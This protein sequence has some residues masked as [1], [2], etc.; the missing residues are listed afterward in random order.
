[1]SSVTERPSRSGGL[2][3]FSGGKSARK[4]GLIVSDSVG[5]HVGFIFMGGGIIFL[6]FGEGPGYG[7]GLDQGYPPL[8]LF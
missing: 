2:M 5:S 4:D 1:M 8:K 7:R 6:S 3:S